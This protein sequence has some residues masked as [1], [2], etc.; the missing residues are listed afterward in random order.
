MDFDR[1]PNAMDRYQTTLWKRYGTKVRSVGAAPVKPVAAYICNHI[2]DDVESITIYRVV[3]S[4]T[5]DGPVGEPTPHK[6]V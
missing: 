6:Q 2:G 4:V 3:Q 1:P 5:A